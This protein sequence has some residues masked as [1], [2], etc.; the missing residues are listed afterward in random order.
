VFKEEEKIT[1]IKLIYLATLIPIMIVVSFL[2]LHFNIDPMKILVYL[3]T[4]LLVFT[5]FLYEYFFQYIKGFLYLFL[6]LINYS[7]SS[8]SFVN[9]LSQHLVLLFGER[10]FYIYLTI[11]PGIFLVLY[12]SILLFKFIKKYPVVKNNGTTG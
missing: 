10:F 5:A 9:P 6:L 12:G 8:Q 11:I 2:S 4:I 7:T 3:F 1:R